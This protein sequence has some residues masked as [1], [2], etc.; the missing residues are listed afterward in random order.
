M[1]GGGKGEGRGMV[2]G[3]EKHS[4]TWIFV[5]F[6]CTQANLH[7]LFPNSLF[8]NKCVSVKFDFLTTKQHPKHLSHCLATV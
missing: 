7:A 2:I 6:K 8:V 4:C 5:K 3:S 1:G